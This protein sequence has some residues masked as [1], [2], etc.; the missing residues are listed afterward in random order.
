MVCF[1]MICI[2]LPHTCYTIYHVSCSIII[3]NSLRYKGIG[4]R[5]RYLVAREGNKVIIPVS[6]IPS[7]LKNDCCCRFL[8]EWRMAHGAYLPPPQTTN[9]PV[10]GYS[11]LNSCSTSKKVASDLESRTNSQVSTIMSKPAAEIEMGSTTPNDHQDRPKTHGLAIASL[12]CGIVGLFV[13]F[14]VILGPLAIFL[15]VMAINQINEKPHEVPG[16]FM[17]KCGIVLGF[18]GIAISIVVIYFVV[19]NK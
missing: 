18:L 14:G 6:G 19:K 2:Q 1:D 17:A 3:I 11:T 12:V 16:K 15:G 7:I 8:A 4:T 5:S 9:R 13:I 10:G